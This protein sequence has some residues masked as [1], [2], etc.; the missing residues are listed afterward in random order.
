MPTDPSEPRPSQHIARLEQGF[1]LFMALIVGLATPAAGLVALLAMGSMSFGVDAVGER[2]VR[3]GGAGVGGSMGHGR[4]EARP[5]PALLAGEDDP[6]PDAAASEPVAVEA[7]SIERAP[8]GPEAPGASGEGFGPV[9]QGGGERSMLA[10]LEDEPGGLVSLGSEHP[11]AGQPWGTVRHGTGSSQGAAGGGVAVVGPAAA[12]GPGRAGAGPPRSHRVDAAAGMR[13]VAIEGGGFWMGS[14][15]DEAGRF[16]N[17]GPRHRVQLSPFW[18]AAT[19]V[20]QAQWRAVMGSL[21]PGAQGGELPVVG[22]SWCDALRFANALSER[23]GLQPAY[24]FEGPCAHGGEVDWD[25][26]ADGYRLPTEAEWE[27]A[28]RAGGEQRFAGSERLEAVGWFLDN[29]QG[30]PRAVAGLSANGFGLHDMSGN[31]WEWVWDRL[32]DY[33]LDEQRDPMG[34]HQGAT[35]ILRG[36]SWRYQARYARVADRNWGRPGYRSPAV[37]FRLARSLRP[38]DLDALVSED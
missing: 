25:R 1:E 6:R 10:S 36:G 14:P 7:A 33:P 30:S 28:A 38:G 11:G 37:G 26:R 19:E 12:A 4:G 35:R 21:P 22:V 16:D 34:P 23:E 8:P 32:G 5:H 2:L 15:E 18:L 29:A 13:L 9:E 24:R 3:W 17:E 20:T 27:Y 31:V